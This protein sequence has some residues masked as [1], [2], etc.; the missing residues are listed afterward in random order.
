MTS[1]YLS[2]LCWLL[3][4]LVVTRWLQELQ[5][6]SVYSRRKEIVFLFPGHTTQGLRLALIGS[7]WFYDYSCT[8]VCGQG[9]G[10]CS[11]APA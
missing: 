4:H 2:S 6:A 8:Q 3:S 9:N 10:V 11:L 7:N 1:L 5:A